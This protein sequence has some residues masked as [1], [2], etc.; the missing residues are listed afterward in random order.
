MNAKNYYVNVPFQ[1]AQICKSKSKALK[2]S[3]EMLKTFKEQTYEV[4]SVYESALTIY[5]SR[6]LQLKAT[7][8][9]TI[10]QC[11]VTINHSFMVFKTESSNSNAFFE[12]IARELLHMCQT[13]KESIRRFSLTN[14]NY[15]LK[16]HIKFL[17]HLLD[18]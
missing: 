5:T 3:Q 13:L 18:L 15:R 17:N 2:V 8:I 10:N 4:L 12:K 14:E 6:L 7:E 1:Y 11:I 9:A 16:L